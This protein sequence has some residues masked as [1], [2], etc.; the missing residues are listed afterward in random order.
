MKIE[1]QVFTALE[2]KSE[3]W[4]LITT[5]VVFHFGANSRAELMDPNFEKQSHQKEIIGPSII[6]PLKIRF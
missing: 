2:K 6:D 3:A 4:A 5:L 1:E